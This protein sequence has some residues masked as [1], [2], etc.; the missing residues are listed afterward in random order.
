MKE[1]KIAHKIIKIFKIFKPLSL[2]ML[3]LF[4]T[5]IDNTKLIAASG[6]VVELEVENT[7]KKEDKKDKKENVVKEILEDDDI[8]DKTSAQSKQENKEQIAKN[9]NKIGTIS[10]NVGVDN[11]VYNGDKRYENRQFLNFKTKSGKEFYLIVNYEKNSEQVQFLSDVSEAELLEIIKET[12]GEKY[13]TEKQDIQDTT[14]AREELAKEIKKELEKE[15][16]EEQAK[17]TNKKNSSLIDFIPYIAIGCVVGYFL[18]N[19]RK[20]AKEKENFENKDVRQNNSLYDE[21][22]HDEDDE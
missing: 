18:Y 5:N 13:A 6:N 11:K 12:K 14:K 19:R 16:K 21:E 7:E 8:Q 15:N 3:S 9:N 20:K 1:K 4:L 17:K 2:L 10:D 22:E